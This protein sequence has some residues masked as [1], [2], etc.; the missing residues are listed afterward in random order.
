MSATE[1]AGGPLL[2]RFE[3]YLLVERGLARPT[4]SSYLSDVRQFLLSLPAAASA[5]E[6]VRRTE[7]QHYAAGLGR[8]GLA[9]ASVARKLVSIR[10]F[11]RLVSAELRL[12][13]NPADDLELPKAV[14]RLPDVLNQQQVEQLILAV[15][16]ASD[17]CWALRSRAMIEVMYGAGLR[18]SELLN[19]R[20]VDLSLPDRFV[21]VVGKRGK[22][23]L[24]PLGSCAVTAVR[25]YVDQARAH[26][27]GRRT[28][29][30]LFLNRRGTR[31]SRMGFAKILRQCLTLAGIRRRVTPHTLRHSFA[32]H[33]LE[34]GADLRS[35]QELLGHAS[36]TTTQI[37]THVDREY[38]REVYRTFHPRG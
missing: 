11:Y 18:V 2:D 14:R 3:S 5:P 29:E 16:Q 24:V 10:V 17:R 7:L 1:S 13:V 32:T 34:G 15:A 26:L 20:V 35:V 27:V 36:I 22:E 28:S 37:Y 12:S 21:R 4:V 38:I 23:R 31:L 33:L 19:L 25:D 9:R 30:Q 6:S 8:A